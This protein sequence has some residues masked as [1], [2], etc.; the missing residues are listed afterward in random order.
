MVRLMLTN[1]KDIFVK[2]Y[3]C[4]RSGDDLNCKR[5]LESLSPSYLESGIYKDLYLALFCWSMKDYHYDD[6]S[7]SKYEFFLVVKNSLELLDRFSFSSKPQFLKLK[8]GFYGDNYG[9]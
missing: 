9:S 3:H 2:A 6:E 4:A 7:R 1:Q 8:S 5:Y